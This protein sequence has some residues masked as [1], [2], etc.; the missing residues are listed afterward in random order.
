MICIQY[1]DPPKGLVVLLCS[2]LVLGLGSTLVLSLL[3]LEK[4]A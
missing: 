2:T 4:R 1:D 3:T